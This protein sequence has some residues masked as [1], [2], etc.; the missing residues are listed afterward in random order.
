VGVVLN[1]GGDAASVIVPTEHALE[2]IVIFVDFSV[3]EDWSLLV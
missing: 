1:E 2:K 3:V